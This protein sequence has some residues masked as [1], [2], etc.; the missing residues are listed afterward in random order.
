L[1]RGEKNALVEITATE[2][3]CDYNKIGGEEE[4]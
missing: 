1:E 2:S 3:W 4:W